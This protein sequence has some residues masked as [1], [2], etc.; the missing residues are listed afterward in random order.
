MNAQNPI[1]EQSAFQQISTQNNQAKQTNTKQEAFQQ[2]CEL[3]LETSLDKTT[4]KLN[5]QEALT[6]LD[7]LKTSTAEQ[8]LKSKADL[9][10]TKLQNLG[11]KDTFDRNK[12][13]ELIQET[14]KAQTKSPS[15][16]DYPGLTVD[17]SSAAALYHPYATKIAK[18]SNSNKTEDKEK[19]DST[20]DTEPEA[21][22]SFLQKIKNLFK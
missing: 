6:K 17:I 20:H 7:I 10:T 1:A 2:N 19:K 8:D 16:A 11:I 22:P 15:K 9:L 18:T 21:K 5:V 3:C 14:F 4:Q 12:V 13:Q